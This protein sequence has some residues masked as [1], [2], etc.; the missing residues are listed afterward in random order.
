VQILSRPAVPP[1]P[2]ISPPA[3]ENASM[4]VYRYELAPGVAS[5]QHT[6]ERPYVILAA[7]DANLRMTSPGGAS[8]DHAFKAGDI[9]W[10][11]SAVTHTLANRGSD[12][13]ILVEIELK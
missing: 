11:D 4:R 7:T 3:A 12:K 8:M 2:A 5:A 1:A 6:H 9:H 10:V 13:A